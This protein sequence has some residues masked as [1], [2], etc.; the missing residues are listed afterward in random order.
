MRSW[1][2]SIFALLV[3][4]SV[5]SAADPALLNLVPADA[6]VAMGANLSQFLASPLAKFA[7]SQIQA[8]DP[9]LQQFIQATGFDPMRDLQ[10]ALIA[11]PGVQKESRGVALLKGTFDPGRLA[12]FAEKSGAVLQTYRGVQVMT[13]KQKTDGWFAFLDNATA[14]AGDAQSV[15]AV[16]DR[17]GSVSQFDPRLRARIDTASATYDFWVVSIAPPSELAGNVP[18]E[19]LNWVMQGDVMKGVL[20]TSGGIKF[21]PEILIAGE[22]LTRSDKDATA[23]TDVARFFIGLAQMSAQKDPKAASAM[24]F[25]QKLQ[26]TTE[27]SVARLSLTVSE[28]DLEN[29]IKQA[30]A[31]AKQQAAAA[32]KKSADQTRPAPGGGLVIRSSPKDM[33]TVVVK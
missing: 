15:R 10:E 25:L 21:G 20:E 18:Q 8:S 13:G 24:A 26:L 16:I 33:G 2:K 31:A 11:S 23:L 28:S 19:Q 1:R 29:F 4:V 14:V 3:G 12:A 7:L 22:A 30:Q 17:R 32:T 27:G 9:R 5:S 6:K